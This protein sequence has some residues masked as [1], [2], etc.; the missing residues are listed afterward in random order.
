MDQRAH[1]HADPASKV[2]SMLRPPTHRNLE[3]C[4]EHGQPYPSER[5]LQVSVQVRPC[6]E[7][8]AYFAVGQSFKIPTS[9]PIFHST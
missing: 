1:G 7:V 9:F 2:L 5:C 3:A 8:L 6:T 4:R